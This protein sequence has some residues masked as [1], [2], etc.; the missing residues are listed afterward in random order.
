M[1]WT[2]PPTFTSSPSTR[3]D[4]ESDLDEIDNGHPVPLLSLRSGI[5]ENRRPSRSG[6]YSSPSNSPSSK[7]RSCNTTTA[8]TVATTTTTTTTTTTFQVPL[9]PPFGS[10]SSILVTSAEK[11]SRQP[12]PQQRYTSTT[13]TLETTDNSKMLYNKSSPSQSPKKSWHPS[14]PLFVPS[15]CSSSNLEVHSDD[16]DNDIGPIN[17]KSRK[18]PTDGLGLIEATIMQTRLEWNQ[19]ILYQ[20]LLPYKAMIRSLDPENFPQDDEDFEY[21]MEFQEESK[22]YAIRSTVNDNDHFFFPFID[23]KYYCFRDHDND[24]DPTNTDIRGIMMK[25]DS[26]TEREVAAFLE[27]M[28]FY[29][30]KV[31]SLQSQLE[32]QKVMN[33][34]RRTA[35]LVFMPHTNQGKSDTERTRMKIGEVSTS[36]YTVAPQSRSP[37]KAQEHSKNT[38]SDPARPKP[39]EKSL[40]AMSIARIRSTVN[41]MDDI[42]EKNTSSLEPSRL[43]QQYGITGSKEDIQKL[44]NELEGLEKIQKRLEK[45]LRQAGVVIAEDIPYDFAKEKVDWIVRRMNEI[46]GCDVDDPA[47]REEYFRLEQDMEKYTAALQLTD[48]WIAEQEALERQW[49]ASIQTSNEEALLKLRRHMPVNVRNISEEALSSQ[50]TPNG[51][52]LPKDIAKKFKRTNCLQLLRVDPDDIV[53]MHPSTLENLRVT[54]LTLTER[55]ALYCHLCQVGPIWKAM[56]SDKMTERK[57]NWFQMMKSN[58]KEN[59]ESWQRHVDQYGPPGNHPYATKENPNCGCPL[60]GKQCPIIADNLFDYS[61]DYGFPQEGLFH[62]SDITK[63]EVDNTAKAKEEV[64]ELA[65]EKKS[66]ERR[67]ALKVHYKG[68]IQQLSLANGTCESMEA[69]LDKMVLMQERLV[70]N[71]L[72]EHA[73]K[74]SH[75]DRHSSIMNEVAAFDEALKELRLLLI[76][77]VQRS[78]K[79]DDDDTRS[80]LEMYLSEEVIESVRYLFSGVEERMVEMDV[81]DGRIKS[82][83]QQVQ[84]LLDELHLRN[85]H[86]IRILGGGGSDDAT[87]HDQ[88]AAAAA[89][90]T[91]QPP[92]RRSRRLKTRETIEA[93]LKREQL[94]MIQSKNNMA[95]SKVEKNKDDANKPLQHGPVGGRMT[96]GPDNTARG[97]LLEALKARGG[98]T[99][100]PVD[101]GG[102]GGLMA[103]IAA[104]R[105]ME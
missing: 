44:L 99:D 15:E 27:G 45:Q 81:K 20:T 66:N 8:P 77:L 36:D 43:V 63:S 101:V 30:T 84:E 39:F 42:P 16:S 22:E 19:R 31:N 57:W 96:G 80:L 100:S 10:Q 46:G 47:L 95:P 89:T 18:L 40:R 12:S 68:D 2:P 71:R 4:G 85:C 28:S 73:G 60:I 14:S 74:G 70:R 98:G 90:T 67:H 61:G 6:L 11:H 93:E 76:S 25:D 91:E 62:K 54:G 88:S 26:L 49:E 94:I 7:I 78:G 64:V 103:A 38:L 102:R 75:T 58:F 13:Q 53:R 17:Q 1:S 72:L 33:R 79:D 59:L 41:A 86:G 92:P 21:N 55:R 34:Q 50:P 82:M 87:R 23:M 65:K 104:R 35:S 56:Q 24:D 32:A 69:A 3:E 29:R 97:A 9:A 5:L 51:K 37:N 52:H 105:K 48:E 83:I